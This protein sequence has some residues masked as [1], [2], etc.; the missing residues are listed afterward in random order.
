MLTLG[1]AC[2]QAAPSLVFER[3]ALACAIPGL[4]VKLE[5]PGVGECP[6]DFAA[7]GTVTGACADVPNGGVIELRL[8]YFVRRGDRSVEL[9]RV[10]HRLDLSDN[11]DPELRVDLTADAFDAAIDDDRDGATN[12]DEVCRGTDPLT[13]G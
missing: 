9:A 10:A 11:A 3:L 8:V 13:G 1:I 12:V 4:E 5:V 6:L 7:D 2:G